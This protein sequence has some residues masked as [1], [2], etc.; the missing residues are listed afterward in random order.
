MKPRL[1][2]TLV[3]LGLAV[4]L[5]AV[6]SVRSQPIVNWFMAQKLLSEADANKRIVLIN[7]SLA[8]DPQ[9]WNPRY[10]RCALLAESDHERKFIADL[11]VERLGTNA[12]VELLGLIE[13]EKSPSARSNGLAVLP[14][15]ETPRK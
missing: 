12:V 9:F 4:C 1:K 2:K 14:L 10:L 5:V 8:Y 11:L 3:L 15:V 13:N 7:T 6:L